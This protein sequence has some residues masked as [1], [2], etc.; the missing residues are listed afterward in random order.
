M[1]LVR[2]VHVSVCRSRTLAT[3]NM[4]GSESQS[5]AHHKSLCTTSCWRSIPI[6]TKAT[7]CE[8]HHWTLRVI[9]TAADPQCLLIEEAGAGIARRGTAVSTDELSPRA[10]RDAVHV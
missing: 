7:I 5:S 10:L 8:E 6:H 1:D 2:S 3:Q 4:R 9:L